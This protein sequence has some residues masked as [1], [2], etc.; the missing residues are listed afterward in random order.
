MVVELVER[1]ELRAEGRLVAVGETDDRG[2]ARA[3]A[4]RL[5]PVADVPAVEAR[6][7]CQDEARREVQDV[8][9]EEAQAALAPARADE[10][11]HAPRRVNDLVARAA[12]LARLEAR[13]DG[14]ARADGSRPLER[15]AHALRGH[16]LKPRQRLCV[17]LCG[18][19]REALVEDLR[20]RVR[21]EREV[22]RA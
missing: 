5:P 15:A 6:A 21:A 2:R 10:R 11:G 16:A 12:L 13:G 3:R 8:A 20:A 14:V 4:R 22:A 9:R 17:A 7:G 19:G 18:D 1:G